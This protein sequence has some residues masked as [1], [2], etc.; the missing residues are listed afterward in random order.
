MYISSSEEL[1]FHILDY[2]K[3]YPLSDN[4]LVIAPLSDVEEGLDS[5]AETVPPGQA[6]RQ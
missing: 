1:D 6:A 2:V 4:L 3:E 5:V